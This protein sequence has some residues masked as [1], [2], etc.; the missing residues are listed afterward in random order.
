ML[1]T[2]CSYIYIPSS[3][4][5]CVLGFHQVGHSYHRCFYSD[6]IY[7]VYIFLENRRSYIDELGDQNRLSG[8]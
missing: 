2:P 6:K 7:Q 4:E 5:L 3:S 1:L 8:S